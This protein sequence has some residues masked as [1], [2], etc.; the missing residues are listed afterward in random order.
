[1]VIFFLTVELFNFYSCFNNKKQSD[2][3]NQQKQLMQ[4][5]E[6]YENAWASGDFLLVET[7][8]SQNAKRFHTEPDVWDRGKIKNYFAERAKQQ[9]T[10]LKRE[11]VENSW[12]DDRDYLDIV[13]KDSF[14]F[15]AFKTDRFKA[16]HIWQLEL[17]G[18]WKIVY[19][20]GMLNSPCDN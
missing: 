18:E 7:F 1:V 5:I 15:D 17:D 4:T 19:D 16:L 12:K 13:I 9:D 6:D 8:F 10:V 14:A 3:E 2:A 20:I 11:F